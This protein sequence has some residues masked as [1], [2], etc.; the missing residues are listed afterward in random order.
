[1]DDADAALINFLRECVRYGTGKYG[2]SINNIETISELRQQATSYQEQAK[3]LRA[4]AKA[5]RNS[6]K[7]SIPEIEKQARKLEQVAKW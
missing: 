7:C 3:R 2:L 5:I 6:S 4:E 1:M